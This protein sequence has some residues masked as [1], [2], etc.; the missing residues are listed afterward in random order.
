MKF[1]RLTHFMII[2]FLAVTFIVVYLYYTIKDVKKISTEVHKLSQDVLTLSQ[3][4]TSITNT[5]I[6]QAPQCY[7]QPI[8]SNVTQPSQTAPSSSIQVTVQEAQLDDGYESD[9]VDD[10]HK[11]IETIE[12]EK[13]VQEEHV[14]ISQHSEGEH[15]TPVTDEQTIDAKAL[16]AMSYDALKKY[17][18]DKGIDAKGNKDALISKIL[19]S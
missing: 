9:A 4:I 13:Q 3:S 17:C 8:S 10:L 6:S 18:K 15:E 5:L 19:A 1:N 12:D 7:A 16:K 11:I 14:D 2:V